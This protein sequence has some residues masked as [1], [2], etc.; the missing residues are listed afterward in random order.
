M[1]SQRIGSGGNEYGLDFV[2]L[3]DLAE[4]DDRLTYMSLGTD[5]SEEVRVAEHAVRLEGLGPVREP[6]VGRATDTADLLE[7]LAAEADVRVPA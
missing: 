4:L 6:W 5:T 2:G 1:T 7:S 3:E